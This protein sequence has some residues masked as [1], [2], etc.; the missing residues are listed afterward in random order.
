MIEEKMIDRAFAIAKP[1][2][3]LLPGDAG[4]AK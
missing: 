3:C 2:F 4:S 1:D